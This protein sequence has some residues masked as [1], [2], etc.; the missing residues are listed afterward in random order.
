MSFEI[1]PEEWHVTRFVKQ[2]NH[3]LLSP[4]ETRSLP[5]NRNITPEDERKIMLYKES[6]LS[7]RK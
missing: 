4:D 3:K 2:H 7:I 6:G 1:F 5:S